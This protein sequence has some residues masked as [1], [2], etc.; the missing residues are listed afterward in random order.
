MVKQYTIPSIEILYIHSCTSIA[1]V[2]L[3]SRYDEIL[4]NCQIYLYVYFMLHILYRCISEKT[5]NKKEKELD[6]LL[7][8]LP[9]EVRNCLAHFDSKFTLHCMFTHIGLNLS[10]CNMVYI[11]EFIY[12]SNMVYI[13]EF[14]YFT[15]F[16]DIVF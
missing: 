1:S 16:V 4:C 3:V 11:L 14:I 6:W 15:P 2:M 8:I 12:F 13:L 5:N 7:G 9:V 10:N